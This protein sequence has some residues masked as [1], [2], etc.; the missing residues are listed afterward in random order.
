MK[1]KIYKLEHPEQG[2]VYIGRTTLT[3]KRRM[4]GGYKGTCVEHIAHE[5][6]MILL[7]E[8]DNLGRERYWIDHYGY[9]N[10]LNI[11]KGDT[12]LSKKESKRLV[13]LEYYYN[14]KEKYMENQR[15][16]RKKKKEEK[17][18]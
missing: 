2:V 18:T 14:N 5:C 13:G 11:M 10:L 3:L 4:N 17:N 1:Y 12:G 8:T 9:D 7:E 6:D 15:K 16:R